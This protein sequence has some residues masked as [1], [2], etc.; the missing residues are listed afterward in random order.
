MSDADIGARVRAVWNDRENRPPEAVLG[1][2]RP[3]LL[4]ALGLAA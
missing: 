4:E 1:P 2:P 3:E